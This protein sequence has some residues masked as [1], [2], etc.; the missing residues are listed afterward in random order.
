MT[1]NLQ[2]HADLRHAPPDARRDG[3][4]RVYGILQEI[5]QVTADVFLILRGEL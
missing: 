5:F 1:L 4:R 3:R 2:I